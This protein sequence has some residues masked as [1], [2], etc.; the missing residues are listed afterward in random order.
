MTVGLEHELNTCSHTHSYTKIAERFIPCSPPVLFPVTF[1]DAAL[2]HMHAYSQLTSI[3]LPFLCLRVPKQGSEVMGIFRQSIKVLSRCDSCVC[4]WVFLLAVT[5]QRVLFLSICL[6]CFYGL[7]FIF[8]EEVN[9]HIKISDCFVS[10]LPG[11]SKDDIHPTFFSV[12]LS[13]CLLFVV[14]HGRWY[15]VANARPG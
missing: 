13:F 8:P 12:L 1:S 3:R 15:D 10:E 14:H 5:R 6:L 9:W 11:E 7:F 4:L 2:D